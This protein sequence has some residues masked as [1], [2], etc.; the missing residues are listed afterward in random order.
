MLID[1]EDSEEYQ[2]LDGLSLAG[3]IAYDRIALLHP[4]MTAVRSQYEAL[5]YTTL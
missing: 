4:K 1:D 3:N 5:F 2:N